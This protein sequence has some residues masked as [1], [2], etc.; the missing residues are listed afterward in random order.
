MAEKT[1]KTEKGTEKKKKSFFKNVKAEYSKI[2][3]PTKQTLGKETVAVVLSTAFLAGLISL[4]DAAIKLGIG[5][6]SGLGV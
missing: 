2:V 4:L 6:V 5:F 3:W 1:E